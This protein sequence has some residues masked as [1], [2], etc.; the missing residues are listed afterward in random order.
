MLSC[1]S[2]AQYPPRAFKVTSELDAGFS[3]NGSSGVFT[4]S[5]LA[6]LVLFQLKYLSR[7]QPPA[8]LVRALW[9]GMR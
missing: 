3:N 4:G 7:D 1:L 8:S 5:H 6:F 9:G 2:V